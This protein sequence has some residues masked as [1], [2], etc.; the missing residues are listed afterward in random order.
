MTDACIQAP[1]GIVRAGLRAGPAS[2][3]LRS[4]IDVDVAVT[5]E[6]HH[7]ERP[8]G[9]CLD[10]LSA[11]SAA[12]EVELDESSAVVTRHH[13]GPSIIRSMAPRSV[14]SVRAAARISSGLTMA[15]K[16]CSSS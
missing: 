15:A 1:D 14:A 8:R 16:A 10:A 11:S 2:S 4:P 9:A 5:E 6:R 13:R 12:T 3:A 7:P